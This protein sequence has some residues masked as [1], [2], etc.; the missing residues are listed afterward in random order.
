M[1]RFWDFQLSG[2]TPLLS[3]VVRPF[4]SGESAFPTKLDDD[5]R[6]HLG[7]LGIEWR[8][9]EEGEQLGF[10]A[11]W[12]SVFGDAFRGR[13]RLR[14]AAKAEYE[15][16]QQPCTHH[17]IVPFTS[18]VPGTSVHVY[19]RAIGAYECHGGLVPL[20]RFCDAEFFVSPMDLGW[21]L[22]HTHEDYAFDGPYFL[23]REWLR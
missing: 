15:Y 16:L 1:I 18:G 22:L 10:E 8:L 9:L 14:R 5:L 4:C 21:T 20:G 2:A 17:L 12:R 3:F 19:R 23:R 13:R 11:E 6:E 7:N